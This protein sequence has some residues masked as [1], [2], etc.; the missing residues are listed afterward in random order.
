MDFELNNIPEDESFSECSPERV[1]VF[2]N[3]DI[4]FRILYTI[5]QLTHLTYVNLIHSQRYTESEN[6]IILLSV[7]I[8]LLGIQNCSIAFYPW[9]KNLR[10]VLYST[11]IVLMIFVS[12]KDT[13][14]LL[15]LEKKRWDLNYRVAEFFFFFV[16]LPNLTS[17]FLTVLMFMIIVLMFTIVLIL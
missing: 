15:F 1:K 3:F 16:L 6:R 7:V 8:I 9:M 2:K 11:F 13:R 4:S 12:V 17:I 10:L 5:F 14:T